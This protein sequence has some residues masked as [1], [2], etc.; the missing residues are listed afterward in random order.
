MS[1]TPKAE[2]VRTFFR[3]CFTMPL[4]LLVH[5]IRGFD[6][7]KREKKSKGYV[8]IFYLAMML[9]VQVIAYNGIGYLVNK[10]NPDDF[11][12]F[13]TMALIL[14]PV[15]VFTVG[16]WATAALFDG[17]GTLND[18]FRVLCYS[19]FPYVWL[20]FVA[21]AISNYITID[22]IVFYTFFQFLGSF[23]LGYMVFFGLMGIH[24]YGLM[25][26]VLMLVFTV[27]AIAVILFIMILFFSLIQKVISVF[28]SIYDEFAWR[29]LG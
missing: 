16:N 24:E 6:E 8:A 25:K 15:A 3:D 14:F 12:L 27:V 7:F 1:W 5:P 26:T 17:K 4:F 13:L 2:T 22:E 10:S 11:N 19:F 28:R 23:L 20:S 21:V 18:I 29:F 9:L